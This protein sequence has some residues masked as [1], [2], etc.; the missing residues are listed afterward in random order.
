MADPEERASW[1]HFPLRQAYQF[2]EEH[3]LKEGMSQ[4]KEMDFG[5]DRPGGG[6]LRRGFVLELLEEKG[7]FQQFKD[8]HWRNG[9]TSDGEG[10]TRCYRKVKREYDD[11]MSGADAGSD[12]CIAHEQEFAYEADLRDFLARNL[13]V[14]EPGLYLYE[15]AKQCLGVE[16]PIDGGRIDILARDEYHRFVVIE[17]KVSRGRNPT[18]GQVLYYMGWVDKHLAEGGK[19]RGIIVAKEIS[20]DLRL[21]CKRVPGLSLYK[22]K[23][24]VAVE[25]VFS[26]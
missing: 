2:G 12:G 7:L 15:D 25:K 17:L 5:W 20:N 6:R 3:H 19:S 22:Y 11:F 24:S 14:V 8:A 26:G 13:Y 9:D 18:I 1:R 21:A 4:I 23:L 10:L 16:Y